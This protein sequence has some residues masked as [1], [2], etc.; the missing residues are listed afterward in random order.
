MFFSSQ[1]AAI[2]GLFV[3]FAVYT[4]SIVRKIV[5]E[6]TASKFSDWIAQ[7]RSHAI[8]YEMVV[9][10]VV[11]FI[12]YCTWDWVYLGLPI[13]LFT[14]LVTVQIVSFVLFEM[15]F[16]AARF[17]S[18]EY[19]WLFTKLKE[20]YLSYFPNDREFSDTNHSN[21]RHSSERTTFSREWWERV[22]QT[23]SSP[24][25][26]PFPQPPRNFYPNS[27]MEQNEFQPQT[28]P[29]TPFSPFYA[30]KDFK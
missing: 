9:F 15:L 28:P 29:S 26:T 5:P 11:G 25:Q 24:S 2:L 6:S 19:S 20:I 21:G 30:N 10:S 7:K 27:G 14:V 13:H 12:F 3:I 22:Q 8:I 4:V 23:R 18:V 16:T 1:F 17:A